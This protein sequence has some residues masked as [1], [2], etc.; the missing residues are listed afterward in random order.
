MFFF[1]FAFLPLNESINLK[2]WV[3]AAD[4]ICLGLGV[5]VNFWPCGE[6]YF[7]SGRL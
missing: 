2:N 5:G 4:K 7:L 3:N 6:G 1:A